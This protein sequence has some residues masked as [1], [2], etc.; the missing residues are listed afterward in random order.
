MGLVFCWTC[1]S[2]DPNNTSETSHFCGSDDLC[3]DN[4]VVRTT[5]PCTPGAA[6]C[7]ET[8]AKLAR[9]C[10]PSA[11][12]QVAGWVYFTCA[13]DETCEE[14]ACIGGCTP[15][16]REC[17]SSDL[18][19]ECTG[20]AWNTTACS[21]GAV[22][23]NGHCTDPAPDA[24]TVRIEP[25]CAYAEALAGSLSDYGVCDG[26]QLVRCL[27]SGQLADD[28]TDCESGDCV[29]L[30]GTHIVEVGTCG[31]TCRAGER[32]CLY[33]R[34][35]GLDVGSGGQANTPLYIECVNRVWNSD[36]A[37]C[38]G[39]ALCYELPGDE[40]TPG[41]IVCGGECNP[42][43]RRCVENGSESSQAIETCQ[44]DAHFGAPE[45][46]DLGVCVNEPGEPLGNARCTPN[47]DG[48]I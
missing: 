2:S 22:C 11:D 28:A 32:R 26:D 45:P 39:G 30:P 13:D 25:A 5:E 24:S 10:P 1:K 19:R 17:I 9:S 43:S 8:S 41:D 37:Y 40:S 48:G 21:V 14:G 44:Q 34:D 29:L 6:E 4:T 38:S 35:A 46:C 12:P 20:G 42:G 7:V 23:V 3:D 16:A 31:G 15:G 33:E 36:S 27:E 18:A 47:E